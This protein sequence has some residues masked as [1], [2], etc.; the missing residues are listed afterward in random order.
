M[1]TY[2]FEHKGV[3][4]KLKTA[5]AKYLCDDC[6]IFNMCINS[7]ETEEITKTHCQGR[8]YKPANKA[9]ER[10][11]TLFAVKQRLTS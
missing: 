10:K 1:K 6:V 9:T 4:Y 7:L 8:I 11:L 2:N 5:P 3:V